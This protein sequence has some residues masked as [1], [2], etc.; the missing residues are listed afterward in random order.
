ML[1]L[2]LRSPVQDR[3]IPA[4]AKGGRVSSRANQRGT[5]GLESVHSQ[6]DVAGTKQ[7]NSGLSQLRQ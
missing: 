4:K 7:R 6:N 3:Q 1:R 2:P 5:L